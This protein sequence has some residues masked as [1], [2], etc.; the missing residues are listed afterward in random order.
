MF[1]KIIN[2]QEVCFVVLPTYVE[3]VG[4]QG[5]SCRVFKRIGEVRL[6]GMWGGR[7]KRLLDGFYA[8]TP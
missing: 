2:R 1:I 3:R 8:L 5:C 4:E 7:P 6:E